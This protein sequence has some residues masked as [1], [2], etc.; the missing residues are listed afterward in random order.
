VLITGAS[1]GIGLA[2]SELF[3]QNGFTVFALSR[4]PSPDTRLHPGGGAIYPVKCDVSDTASV[5]NAAR[6]IQAQA[7][8]GIVIHSAG[9]GIACSTEDYPAQAVTGLM[10]TNFGGVLRVNSL[11]LPHF[12]KRGG[13]LCLIIGSLAGIFSI[14]FQSHYCASKAA[15]DSYASAA[16]MELRDYGIKVSLVMPGD[17]STGFTGAR[18]YFISESSPLYDACVRSVGKM[19]QDELHGCSP[20]SIARVIFKICSKKNPPARKIVGFGYKLLSLMKKILPNRLA[21]FILRRLYLG[22]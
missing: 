9:I 8:V 5:E 22:V 15:L 7:D 10:E 20:E 17:A 4:N 14:P 11:F 19:E 13:G 18:K 6:T 3:A 16:R 21:E 12:R 2:V 1:S